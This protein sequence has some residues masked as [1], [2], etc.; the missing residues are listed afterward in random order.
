MTRWLSL[1]ILLGIIVAVSIVFYRVMI[2][3][4]LPLFLAAILVI[5]FRPIYRWCLKRWK[6][7]QRLAAAITTASVVLIVIVPTTLLVTLAAAEAS[8][9]PAQLKDQKIK[10]KLTD[11]RRKLELEYPFAAEMRY[12]ESSLA[13][14]REDALHGATAH[15]EPAAYERLV[16]AAQQLHDRLVA[17]N[18]SVHSL[19]DAQRMFEQLRAIGSDPKRLGTLQYQEALQQSADAFRKF[20]LELLGG[21]YRAWL[22]EQANPTEEELTA[23]TGKFFAGAPGFLRSVGGA[24]T[25]FMATVGLQ[26]IIMILAMYFFLVDGPA[27]I[28]NVMRL[29]PLDDA[30][31]RELIEEFDRIS[32]AVVLATLLSAVVQ[33]ALAGLGFWIAG[34][35]SVFLL[36][37]ITIIFALVPFV[38]AASV[39][40]PACLWLYFY[41][42]RTWAAVLLAIYGAVIV[43]MSDNFIKPLVLH[44]QSNL[45]PLLALLSVLGGVQ[46]LGPIGIL[47][48]PMVVVF[49]QTL[50]N[51]LHRELMSMER[52]PGPM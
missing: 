44:G 2:G 47:V 22:K 14:L 52:K 45:H 19:P 36:S 37:M 46:A 29:S 34:V 11:L 50:L 32:R 35:G 10:Q 25:G 15:G 12:L 41:E 26:S 42:G 8:S 13:N 24:T 1:A 21:E 6:G 7:R 27:M 4:L 28:E 31:E 3:F 43:S 20:K 23:L 16:D 18:H 38:G 30:H 51:I 39:W 17:E 48:G 5:M 40:L 33:G 9:L 49:L